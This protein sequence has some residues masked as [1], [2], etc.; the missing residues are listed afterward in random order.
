[1]SDPNNYKSFAESWI[2]QHSA[3]AKSPLQRPA[4]IKEFGAAVGGAHV[5]QL[6]GT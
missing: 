2:A 6:L 4:I 1:M 3:D 5:G